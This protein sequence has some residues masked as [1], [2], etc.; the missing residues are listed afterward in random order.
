MA[1]EFTTNKSAATRMLPTFDFRN[2]LSRL[3]DRKP[4][5]QDRIF[6]TEQLALL[7]ETGT[8]LHAAL[9]SMISQA[10]KSSVEKIMCKLRDDVEQG[11]SFAHALQQ[12][13]EFFSKSYVNLVAAAE[14]GGFL[15]RV[16]AELK[17]LDEKRIKLKSRVTAALI[18]PVFL[19]LF[20]IGVVIFVLT[21]VFPK[22]ADLFIK[23]NHD[24]P[25]S[26]QFL[27]AASNAM[28][29]HWLIISIAT[30]L[31]TGAL[32]YWMRTEKGKHTIDR[33]KLSMFGIRDIFI[34][35]YL[36][37]S[38]RLM[39]LSL[40]N[41]V[42]VMDT[43]DACKEVVS[44]Y[45]FNQFVRDLQTKVKEGAGFATGFAEQEFIPST[46]KQMIKTGD[47]SGNLHHVMHRIADHYEAE[48]QKKLDMFTRLVEP[49]ML[50]LMGSLVGVIVSS[51]ILP[52]FK[53]SKA[54]G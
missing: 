49:I 39:G 1:I 50:L 5:V 11:A 33:L 43:L 53:L 7:L 4:E 52:I 37:Q 9:H 31:V 18:Y 3:L 42:T 48:L 35:M 27:M 51:L 38:L 15:D 45:T 32:V 17:E 2:M 22:F 34:Q 14:G 6:F 21:I 25:A 12:H 29:N 41:G 54:V 47:D 28:V 23:I 10:P 24:L 13:P 8:T 40:A 30:C 26:T 20:S 19:L 44:N 16:L 46:V 36:V